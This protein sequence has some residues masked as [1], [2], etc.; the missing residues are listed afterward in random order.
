M[1]YM[2]F[3]DLSGDSDNGGT[4]ALIASIFS[5]AA[6]VASTAIATSNQPTINPALYNY[7]SGNQVAGAG[8]MFPHQG[9][10]VGILAVLAIGAVAFVLL[11]K[12][13]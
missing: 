4:S 12:R 9:S 6:S 13:G 11:R 10:S 3:D 1:E 5:D 7:G 2:N 8:L